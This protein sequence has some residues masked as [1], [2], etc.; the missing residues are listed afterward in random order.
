G[1]TF[2][3]GRRRRPD[4]PRQPVLAARVA[5][6][7]PSRDPIRRLR[8]AVVAVAVMVALAGACTN[9]PDTRL[10]PDRPTVTYAPLQHPFRGARLFVDDQTA[11]APW[12]RENGAGWLDP[13]PTRPQA[14][15]LNGPQDLARLPALAARARR[16]RALLVLVA[17]SLPSPGCNPSGQAAPTS[18][19]YRR[20]IAR[21]IDPLGATRAAIVV[22]PDG[23]A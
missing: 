12:P 20:W 13:I 4:L 7:T 1:G 15:G 22:E 8:C 14:L 16:Q 6:G 18:G 3:L 21:L 23:V 10:R 2:G 17:Y 5:M 9:T 19:H 11:G